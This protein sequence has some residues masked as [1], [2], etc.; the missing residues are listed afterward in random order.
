M[1]INDLIAT[2]VHEDKLVPFLPLRGVSKRR[3]F[4]SSKVIN[5][6]DIPS[7]AVNALGASGFVKAALTRWVLGEQIY[8]GYLKKLGEPP[9]GIWEIRVTQPTAQFRVFLRF[10]EKDTIIVSGIYSRGRLGKRGSNEWS[11]AMNECASFW[12]E[13]FEGHMY[14][15]NG[16]RSTGYISEA[17]DDFKV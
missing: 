15:E 6:I 16:N 14:F 10:A 12:S 3:A 8:K 11:A 1:S 4:L 13:L 9:T 2:K 7:S 17:C 5:E